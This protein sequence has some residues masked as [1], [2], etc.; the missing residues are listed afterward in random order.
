MSKFECES[1]HVIDAVDDKEFQEQTQAAL[2]RET[3]PGA[4]L[5]LQVCQVLLPLFD[6]LAR[7]LDL[8]G[9]HVCAAVS[10][11]CVSLVTTCISRVAQKGFNSEALV[12]TLGL[13]VENL[14]DLD[15]DIRQTLMNTMTKYLEDRLPEEAR[16]AKKEE[17]QWLN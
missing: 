17:K 16:K 8:N 6:R 9:P 13:L 5:T 12:T 7:D 2:A 4:R 10:S 14:P 15:E 3:D 1:D 11:I